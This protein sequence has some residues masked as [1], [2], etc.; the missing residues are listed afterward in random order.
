MAL[1]ENAK[2]H[3]GPLL[4]RGQSNSDWRLTTGFE[5]CLGL[6]SSFAYLKALD[7]EATILEEF[8]RFAALDL[9]L[10]PP[11]VHSLE[12]LALLQHYGGPTR[13]LDVTTS[14]YVAAYF[15]TDGASHDAAIWMIGAREVPPSPSSSRKHE[16]PEDERADWL[17]EQHKPGKAREHGVVEFVPRFGNV[18]LRNQRARFLVAKDIGQS[19]EENLRKT[20]DL[21]GHDV[22]LRNRSLDELKR[23][24]FRD[25]RLIKVVIPGAGVRQLE[26][27]LDQ[28]GINSASLFPGL[29]GFGKSLRTHF[30]NW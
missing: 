25:I 1:A 2:K 23:E 21:P 20:L 27:E 14:V 26:R 29:D 8:R 5:R 3:L 16:A 30:L 4:F 24:R 28:M 18:R 12:W 15:A 6:V 19:F 7:K 17:A 22:P 10:L 9:P 11:E 13:L